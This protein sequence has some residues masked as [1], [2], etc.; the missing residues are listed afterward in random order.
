MKAVGFY[1]PSKMF[2]LGTSPTLPPVLIDMVGVGKRR[3]RAQRKSLL[4]KSSVAVSP[5]VIRQ[6]IIR[7]LLRDRITGA[8]GRP[9][10]M[11]MT[12]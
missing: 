11:R 8:L 3:S 4:A 7:D 12:S 1:A 5:S 6:L 2:A 10:A 9:A